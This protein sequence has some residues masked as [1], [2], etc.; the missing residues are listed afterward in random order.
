M[1]RKLASSLFG[2][3]RKSKSQIARTHKPF[4]KRGRSGFSFE[5]LEDR[6]LLA[7]T[8][9]ENG[10]AAYN[11]TQ[12][13]GI[14]SIAPN[15]NF[16]TEV[17]ISPD[18]QDANGVRQGLM[19]FDN[20]F[21]DGPGQ[22]PLGSTINSATLELSVVNSSFT[23]MQMSFYRVLTPWS[24]ATATWNGFGQIGGM[25]AS[26]N[27]VTDLPPDAI[28]FDPSTGVKSIDVSR[29]L[30]SWS[31]GQANLGWMIESASSDG[32]DFETS[33]AAIG[34]RPK[35]TVNY[36]APTG[37]GQI[38]LLDTAP[39]IAEGDAGTT[40]ATITVSRLGG[41]TGEVSANYTVA[42][43]TAAGTDFVADA[44]TVTFAAGQTTATIDVVINGDTVLEGNKTVAITL[45]APTN[46]AT[47]GASVATLTI[48]DDDA[49][50]NEVLANVSDDPGSATGPVDETNREFVELIGTPNASLAGYY[51]VVFESEEE[52]L[53]GTDGAGAGIADFVFDLSP[54]SFG[55]NG[56]LVITPTNWAYTAAAGT[57]VV[58][59]A[60]LDGA[61]GV[62]EDESQTYALI[63]SSQP[64]VQ[65]TDYD[66]VGAYENPSVTAIGTGVGIL[67]HPFFLDGTAQMVDSAG[68]VEGGS[69]RDRN[70]TTPELGH[71][72]IHLHQVTGAA[73]SNNVTSDAI[74]RRENNFLPNT[75][76]AWFNGDI[77]DTRVDNTPIEYL[78]GTTRISV[79]APQGSV[80]TPGAP[81]TLRNAFV[82]ADLTSVDEVAG[83]A[84]FTV[85]RTGDLSQAIDVAFTTQDGTARVVDNDYVANSGVLQFG[86]G[87]ASMPIT[88][89]INDD[90]VAEGFE[91]FSVVLTSVDSPFL[92]VGGPAT[93]TI[94]DADV[95]VA[96]FQ[97]G[98]SGY[99]GTT[100][101]Y[102]DASDPGF[103]FSLNESLTVDDAQGE[104]EVVGADIRP[105]QGMIRFDNIF[106]N[107]MGQVPEGAQIFGGF[108]TVNVLSPSSSDA[109]IQLYR[110]LQDWDG[111][112]SWTDPQGA[113]GSSMLNGVTPD[114]VEAAHVADAAVTTPAQ[115]G[116]VQ[117]P[118]SVDTLQAWANGSLPN[119]GWTIVSDSPNSWSIAASEDSSLDP[120]APE[121]TILYNAPSAVAGEGQFQF[122]VDEFLV[123]EGGAVTITVQ[124]VGGS[125]GA[126]SVNY[127]VTAG[128]GALA[129]LS[130]TLAGTLNFAAGEFKKTFN[131]TALNDILIETN[132]TFNLT[133]SAPSAG[134][135]VSTQAGASLLTVR[136]NDASTTSPPVLMSEVLFNQPANDGGSEILEIAGTPGVGLGSFYVVVIGGDV[137]DDEGATNLV[138]DLGSFANGA[139]GTTLVGSA[140]NFNYNVPAGTTFI[141]LD[142]LDVEFVGGND[143][144]SSTYAL[145]YS[146]LTPLLVGRFDYDWDNDGGL[147]L[148]AGAVIVDSIGYKD[149]SSSDT[150]YGGGSNTIITNPTEPYDALSR[151]PGSTGRNNASNW[152]GGDILGGNDALVYNNLVA[153]GLSGAIG[154]VALPSTSPAVTPGLINTGSAV[155][156]PLVT[157]E[158]IDASGGVDVNFSGVM[159]QVLFGDGSPTGFFGAGISVTNTDGSPIPGVDAFPS[160]VAGFGTSTLSLSFSGPATTAGNLPAGTYKLNFVGN[161]LVG[162]GRGVDAAGSGS[163]SNA[164]VQ[165]TV[166]A[167]AIPGDYDGNGVVTGNDLLAWQRVLGATVPMGTGADGDNSGTID[168]GDLDVW[169]NAYPPAVA[170][171]ATAVVAAYEPQ[172]D[173]APGS[174]G[175]SPVSY[176]GFAQAAAS[177]STAP[178]RTARTAYRPSSITATFTLAPP[179]AQSPAIVS[180]AS[181]TPGEFA[182]V[183]SLFADLGDEDD[184]TSLAAAGIGAQLALAL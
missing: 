101:T 31:A 44:G 137:G 183:D 128:T 59:T 56:L 63:R 120:F 160:S 30:R 29:S 107:A 90:G 53:G 69:D 155:A 16:G 24:E 178:S 88:V 162:N 42:A 117:I 73:N 156:N 87:V 106:G 47:L 9:F 112:A 86:V 144:G 115:A 143:N 97:Q 157:L 110:M 108:L 84:T 125:A 27:E 118:L 129:D 62:L 173:S 39:R 28:Q 100:D 164:Q 174:A 77:F 57:T 46:G 177:L 40:T 89:T 147:E 15:V 138:V 79:V 68:V 54:Y 141:G 37:A 60:Q 75:I 98:V 10:V 111:F 49:L 165:F 35:L 179:S 96:T 123:N 1:P 91:R 146:P 172:S 85:T 11:G 26:E 133:L 95:Q 82:T 5:A 105:Q 126:A 74:S 22:I 83:M 127:A 102:L 170:A 180:D 50:I 131:L 139:N 163:A 45:S 18:Q 116:L 51:F 99:A 3:N 6:R 119:F 145:V 93:V 134:A 43:G 76:G 7:V 184:A 168:A 166:T 161:S 130:G 109:S 92:I 103:F 132:K 21:G 65:G 149:N 104:G 176:T 14:F 33:E 36:T 25:Q 150:T 94:N 158:T 17:S 64:I 34:D 13:T 167:A 80:L 20:I 142:E 23:S 169:R 4:A 58:P 171:T 19:R 61:G 152:Y 55:S 135:T 12:D 2:K 70:A 121:L 72:G 81:N 159:S 52:A 124:R 136:D 182:E 114:G 67:D 175:G 113:V 32:W 66:T 71:P 8:S 38:T 148:P 181:P 78:N 122:A 140:N 151:L 153:T 154:G 41:L 48:A